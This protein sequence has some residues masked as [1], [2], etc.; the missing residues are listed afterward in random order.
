MEYASAG[1]LF[2]FIEEG[3]SLSETE[4]KKIMMQCSEAVAFMHR[5]GISHLDLSL[6]NILM[7]ETYDGKLVPKII[8]FGMA[9]EIK[10]TK[11]DASIRRPGKPSYMAP[12]IYSGAQYDPRKADAFS[13]G[14]V[15]FIMLTG[16]PPF[17]ISS[18]HDK[19]FS[20]VVG[21][22]ERMQKICKKW[23]RPISDHS[24]TFVSKL[25]AKAEDRYTVQE[26]VADEYLNST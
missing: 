3:G 5:K 23:N 4:A 9:Q 22:S 2:N 21:S 16:V 14:V 6:E 18:F 26:M 20:F 17:R 25:I 13:L 24:A 1:E 15:H 19:R 7:H 12:E 10:G 8:D 11:H